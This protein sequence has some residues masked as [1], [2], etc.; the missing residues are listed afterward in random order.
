MPRRRRRRCD[1]LL[2]DA[3]DHS[4]LASGL[5]SHGFFDTAAARLSG[6][7]CWSSILRAS[8]KVMPA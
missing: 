1:V 4:G 7:G 5:A 6:K 2:V 3:F 8:G